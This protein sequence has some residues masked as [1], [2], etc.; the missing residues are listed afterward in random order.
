MG[1]NTL[2]PEL[3]YAPKPNEPMRVAGFMSGSGSNIR[4]I[5]EHQ[6]EMAE[7]LYE[8]ILIFTDVADESK[9]KAKQISSEF[10]IPFLCKD[11][12]EF[13]KDMGHENKKDLDLRPAYYAEVVESVRDFKIDLIALGGFMSIVTSPLL[14]EYK[15]INVHPAD[16]SIMGG[17]KRKYT[18]AHAVRDAILAGEKYIRS[19]VHVVR[20][21]VDYGEILAVSEPVE[22]KIPEGI[23]LD[24]LKKSENKELLQKVTDD[25]QNRLKGAGDWVIF[26]MIVEMI[27]R[28]RF[29]VD[30]RGNVFLDGKILENGYRLDG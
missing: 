18:G 5:I 12:L 11:V 8:L 1:N 13:Y 3:L 4:K 9:C 25:N 19:S 10:G 15:I 20:K 28:G 22:V 17:G 27:A 6:R 23:G 29:G 24:N 16:L 21:E 2:F 30:N 7:N 14:D 26:P